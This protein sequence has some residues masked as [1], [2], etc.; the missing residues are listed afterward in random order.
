MS[1]DMGYYG[2][3]DGYA[4]YQEQYEEEPQMP[5]QRRG[6]QSLRNYAQRVDAENQDLKRRLTELEEANRDLLQQPPGYAPQN[7]QQP[8]NV[9]A[10]EQYRPPQFTQ[11]EMLDMQRM[12]ESGVL[13]VAAPAGTDG[14]QIARINACKSPDELTAYLASQGNA[15]LTSYNGRGW[16]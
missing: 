4:D 12:R 14:E 16:E 6:G 7:S 11:A 1:Y 13:G 9:L 5:S 3:G 8:N 10:R 15:N 2:G